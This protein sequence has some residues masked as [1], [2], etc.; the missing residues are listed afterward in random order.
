MN[1]HSECLDGFRS[2]LRLGVALA[3]TI[4]IAKAEAVECSVSFGYGQWPP[5][6]LTKSNG[7]AV[8]LDVEMARAVARQA[9]CRVILIDAPFKRL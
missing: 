5:Y 1:S 3:V 2:A 9:D 4:P 6:Q 8:G 7:K